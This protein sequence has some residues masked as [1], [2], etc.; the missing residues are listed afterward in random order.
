MRTSFEEEEQQCSSNSGTIDV[1]DKKCPKADEV[2]CKRPNYR[3]TKCS[4]FQKPP[5][6][7]TPTPGTPSDPQEPS[8][9]TTDWAQCGRNGTGKIVLSGIENDS[10]TAQ[11]GEF[12]HMCVI[13]RS[14]PLHPPV[15]SLS[16][17]QDAVRTESIRRWSLPH[18]TQQAAHC[19]SQVLGRVRGNLRNCAL[20]NTSP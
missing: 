10:N 7:P 14:V 17:P 19:G 8:E 4:Q 11:P 12:P 5:S 20:S 3:A 15:P 18:R 1:T 6:K 13:Y 2:C 16:S 9:P